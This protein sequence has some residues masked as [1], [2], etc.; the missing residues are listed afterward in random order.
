MKMGIRKAPSVQ[1]Y[2]FIDTFP[3]ARTECSRS[4][5]CRKC[6]ITVCAQ[7]I[8]GQIEH[9]MICD[10]I[11][12]IVQKADAKGVK[13]GCFANDAAMARRWRT[14]GVRFIGYSCDTNIF[15][16]GAKRD[17]AIFKAKE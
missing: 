1:E 15:F 11:R 7:I 16:E 9:P 17:T 13:V 14:L 6:C 12:Q 10:A 2:S 8:V 5:Y 3:E 4:V